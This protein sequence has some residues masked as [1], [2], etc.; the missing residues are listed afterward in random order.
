MSFSTPLGVE[1]G[2]VTKSITLS[3]LNPPYK[4][5]LVEKIGEG[6]SHTHTTLTRNGYVMLHDH[7]EV[8]AKDFV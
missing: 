8:C 1:I 4:V 5:V 6:K 7:C 2:W 3:Q